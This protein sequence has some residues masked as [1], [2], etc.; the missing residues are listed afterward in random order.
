MTVPRAILTVLALHI[1]IAA[2]SSD[3]Q[4]TNL[5]IEKFEKIY[6]QMAPEDEARV[7]V[8]LRLADLLAEKAR[9][10]TNQELAKG[11][12]ECISGRSERTLALK[13]Y[14]ESLDKM[15]EDRRGRV[16][17]QMGHLYELNGDVN[18][19]LALYENIVHSQKDPLLLAEAEI[20]WGELLFRRRDYQQ[21]VV[22]Y[23][24]AL[25]TKEFQRRGYASY[26]LAWSQFNLGET[27]SAIGTLKEMLN[28]PELLTRSGSGN[29]G[30]ISIDKQFQEEISRDLATFVSRRGVTMA[31]VEMVYTE[32][33][34]SVRLENVIYLANELERLG[35]VQP[36]SQVWNFVVIKHSDPER[37]L[38]AH[39]HLAP[40]YLAQG[41]RPLANEEFEK[42]LQL[43][44]QVPHCVSG[45][46][47]ELKQRLKNYVVDWNREE[48][49]KPSSEILLAYQKYL[50]LFPRELDM[51]VWAAMV[52]QQQEQWTKA[53]DL[54]AQAAHLSRD[55]GTSGSANTPSY[56]SILLS[57]IEVGEKSG[58]ADLMNR[59]L[60]N[61]L[62]NS[63][64]KTKW[65]EVHYQKAHHLY[66]SGRYEEASSA[67]RQVVHLPGQGASALRKQAADLA[68]DSLA[69][70]KR[71]HDVETWALEFAQI[72]AQRDASAST[73]G[74]LVSHSG[75]Y[76]DIARRAIL[77]QAVMVSGNMQDPEKIKE[78]DEILHRFD[79]KGAKEP[80]QIA[81][82]KLR[83]QYAEK[84]RNLDQLGSGIKSLLAIQSISSQDRELALASQAWLAELKLDFRGALAATEKLAVSKDTDQRNLQM[85]VYAELAGLASEPYYLQ[86]MK[87][88]ND[89]G[90]RLTAAVKLVENSSY[91]QKTFD[92]LAPVLKNNPEIFSQLQYQI[93]LKTN[94][95]KVALQRLKA[96]H[97][98]NT[99]GAKSL[100][101]KG[102]IQRLLRLQ[103]KITSHTFKVQSDAKLAQSLKQ[104]I[105]M[106]GAFE[107]LLKEAVGK[108]DWTGQVLVVHSL[109]QESERFYNEILALPIPKGLSSEQQAEYMQL[110]TQQAAP[111]Q[112]RATEMKQK[113]KEFWLEPNL[114]TKLESQLPQ[115]AGLVRDQAVSEFRLV[116]EIAPPELK[117]PF[118]QFLSQQLKEIKLPG[119]AELEGAR[120]LVREQP[121]AREPLEKLLLLERRMGTGP[122]VGYLEQRLSQ[123]SDAPQLERKV[124]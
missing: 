122:M 108:D 53:Y 28:S 44:K 70:L 46:C 95:E 7:S 16:F 90:K 72:L 54:Y 93:F 109:A 15:D 1:S 55:S 29:F 43:W 86:F 51:T 62:Q 106:L 74:P 33:P 36:A 5:L 97:I 11:C 19:A 68:L 92:Q 79:L 61:Y 58:S 117:S 120:R 63:K 82:Y 47:T 10:L 13:Y 14:A 27:E 66:Q 110:L 26:R 103:Q 107:N 60:D 17:A 123:L 42:A 98:E 75:E 99:L 12:D 78:A 101:R 2:W 124:E 119:L 121:F 64:D 21:A 80:E 56:E 91:P 37:R 118:E 59:S 18:K 41:N 84:L 89:P 35:Q 52:A 38:E 104:R 32:S 23:Q 71:D 73:D 8:A 100:W 76:Q 69:L 67:F 113:F 87:L 83:I 4:T 25:S 111:H 34:E 116:A 57:Q 48:K 50:D 65:V 81:Y 3:I 20:S 105:G 40:L 24:K 112:I 85:A 77:N 88:T 114:L 22:H 45:S 31:D 39:V 30:V 49:T 102:F 6:L 9:L 94:N 115:Q 96:H